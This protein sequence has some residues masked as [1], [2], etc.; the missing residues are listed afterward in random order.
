MV[1]VHILQQLWE[2]LSTEFRGSIIYKDVHTRTNKFSENYGVS[3][4]EIEDLHLR[5][6]SGGIECF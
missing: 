4:L 2:E 6:F 1:T 3:I 5:S